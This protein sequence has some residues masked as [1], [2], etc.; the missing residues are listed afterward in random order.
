ML[1]PQIARRPQI[2]RML[3][4]STA[5]NLKGTDLSKL[6]PEFRKFKERQSKYNMDD[7]LRVHEKFKSDRLLYNFTTLLVI[8]GF[9]EWCRVVWTLAYPH[10]PTFLTIEVAKE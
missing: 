2:I 4:T 8:V 3:A 9:Y 5:R 1:L 10:W 6:T 7:G